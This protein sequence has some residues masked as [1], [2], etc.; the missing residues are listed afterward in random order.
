MCLTLATGDVAWRWN[1]CIQM[2][3]SS[4]PLTQATGA[5]QSWNHQ[6]QWASKIERR[7]GVGMGGWRGEGRHRTFGSGSGTE[8][9][10]RTQ[11]TAHGLLLLL[12]LQKVGFCEDI[13]HLQV[14]RSRDTLEQ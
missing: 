13:N 2:S 6:Q 3:G 9:Y 12:L 7:E 1:A 10:S 14:G 8:C 11:T 4:E 5:A